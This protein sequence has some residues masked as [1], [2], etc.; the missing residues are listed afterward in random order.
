MIELPGIIGIVCVGIAYVG[1]SVYGVL[2]GKADT[3]FYNDAKGKFRSKKKYGEWNNS[4]NG[5]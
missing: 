2:R 5:Q 1:L 4:N 3:C